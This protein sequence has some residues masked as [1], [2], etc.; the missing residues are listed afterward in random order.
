MIDL[1]DSKGGKIYF[2][3]YPLPYKEVNDDIKTVASQRKVDVIDLQGLFKSLEKS[4]EHLISDW[5]HC[6]E[7]G[8]SIIANTVAEKVDEFIEI[9]NK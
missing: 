7:K 1:V 3:T 6:T 4:R 9:G 8:Y 5:E 2:M